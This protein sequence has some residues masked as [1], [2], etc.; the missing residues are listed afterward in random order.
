MERGRQRALVRVALAASAALCAAWLARLDY[1]RKVSTNVL[2]LIPRGERSPEAAL[3]R[4]FATNLQGRVALFAWRDRSAPDR[5]PEAAAEYFASELSRSPAFAAAVAPAS[6]EDRTT[7]ARWVFDRRFD[8]LLPTWLGAAERAFAATGLPADRFS[9]WLAERAASRLEAFMGSPEAVPMQELVP[10]D[11]LLLVPDLVRSEGALAG[12]GDAAGGNALV[13]AQTKASP[14]VSEGQGPVFAAV[15][16][17]AART[18]ARYPGCEL[19]WTGVSRFAAAS[20]ARIESEIRLLNLC[21]VLAVL[22]VGCALVRRCWRMLHLVPI[23]LLSLLGA[24]TASTI[25]FPRLHVLVFVVGALLCGVA[26]DYGFYIY[27]QPFLGADEPYAGK[28]RRLLRPLLASCLTTVIG[29][30]LLIFSGLPLLREVGFFVS[31]GL[32]CALAAAMAYFAQVDR[33]LLEARAWGR[34]A[35]GPRPGWVR[36]AAAAGFGLAAVVALVGPWRLRWR[37]DVRELEVPAPALQA[38]D[39]ALRVLFGDSSARTVYLT[40]GSTVAEARAHL[41]RFVAR[42]QREDPGAGVASLGL[43]FPTEEDWRALPGRLG[44]LTGFTADFRRALDRHGFIPS[45]FDPFFSAWE[46]MR[47]DPPSGAYDSLYRGAGRA[48]AG[49]LS[50]LYQSRGPLC[51]FLTIVARPGGPPPPR[52]FFTVGLDQLQLLDRLF[53]RYRWSALRLSLLGL[54]LVIAS[55]FAIYPWRRG[56]RIALIP[57]GSC[58]FVLGVFGLT[59]QTLNLFHLLG[60]FLG[61]CLAHNYA[62]F[63]SESIR[64]GA[65]PPPSLRLSA[66]SAAASFG[67]LAFSRI[68]VVHA[69]GLT[70]ALI[71]L[72]ALAVVE[73]EPLLRRGPS[74]P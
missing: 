59:G 74:A 45:A 31:A 39:R 17:A 11:P 50:A 4:Q 60:A 61:V 48:L 65:A 40:Y 54:G 22:A 24:W 32:L 51:W 1:A 67:V 49:P 41:G 6:A 73:F 28:L 3:V 58:F 64:T 68:P 38:N 53:T 63:S 66:L 18:R 62:I 2:D 5:P 8:L 33:P 57:S 10:R 52:G 19:R 12:A 55:V 26:I 71:V 14:F 43:A 34:L 23:I 21:S 37:D 44:R 20:R 27:M 16:A 13:W 15:A 47:G 70:V 7:M 25:V 9:P 29:F 72:T 36:A 69:L 46:R 30:S 35:A 56:L 42:A